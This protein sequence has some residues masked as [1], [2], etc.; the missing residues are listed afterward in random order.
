MLVAWRHWAE[1]R[2]GKELVAKHPD[3][4]ND[5][6]RWHVTEGQKLTGSYLADI[7]ANAHRGLPDN[8]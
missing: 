4:V 8:A 3:L 2:D 1:E 6:V 7:E 5:Y